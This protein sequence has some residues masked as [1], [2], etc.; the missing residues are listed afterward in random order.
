MGRTNW[1]PVVVVAALLAGCTGAGAPDAADDVV[2][3][4]DKAG[5]SGG[6]LVLTMG[7]EGR[8]G[9]PDAEQILY[10]AE[11]LAERSDGRMQ[12]EPVWGAAGDEQDAD[13]DDYPGWD[14]V[15]ARAVVAGELDLAIVPARAWDTEG[16][17]SLR[18]LNTPLLL[19]SE[20]L[21]AEVVTSDLA[22]EMLAG[23]E[24]VGVVGLGLPPESLR[25]FFAFG[26]PPA[27]ATPWAGG[28][29]R[30]P[31]SA[32]VY[33]FLEALGGEPDDLAGGGT[34]R[35]EDGVRDGTVLAAEAA[36]PASNLPEPVTALGGPPLFPKVATLVANGDVFGSLTEADQQ[37]LRDAAAATVAWAAET[38]PNETE[39][40]RAFC[41][42]SIIMPGVPSDELEEAAATVED[43]LRADPATASLI[44]AIRDLAT[45]L[46]ATPTS[47]EPCQPDVEESPAE[48]DA[49]DEDRGAFPEGVYRVE[50]TMD[51]LVEAGVDRGLA[52]DHAG[53]WTMRFADGQLLIEQDGDRG[54]LVDKGVY[55][56]EDGRVALGIDLFSDPPTC[57]NFWSAAW[58]LDG[59]VLRFEDVVSHHG[60]EVL[61]EA[62]WG[63]QPWRQ[64]G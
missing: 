26:D 3:A 64:I 58:E 41:E 48:G 44:D 60:S 47:I 51:S 46:E 15:V 11:Q 45:D 8:P 53:L 28:I 43:D 32:T 21:V 6:T 16:V 18:A 50:H 61:T 57:G 7:T 24:E 14:Q 1:I 9:R 42:R 19:T 12:V 13:A 34:D 4:P 27:S 31:R 33:A 35:F 62:L 59:D 25:R 2:A 29:V 22:D 23:L 10:F 56:V 30:A 54:L 63:S 5:G 17:T 40:A 39:D 55:C 20:E 38:M 52:G 49:D 36:F 37:V